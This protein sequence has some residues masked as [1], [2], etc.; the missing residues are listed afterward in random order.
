MENIFEHIEHIEHK[1][2]FEHYEHYIYKFGKYLVFFLILKTPMVFWWECCLVVAYKE[3]SKLNLNK[4][5]L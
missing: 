5:K 1:E 2:H 3:K 4:R